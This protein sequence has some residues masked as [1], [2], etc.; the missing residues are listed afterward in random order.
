VKPGRPPG[1][2]M[3]CGWRCDARL[4]ARG[5]RAHFNNCTILLVAQ[6]CEARPDHGSAGRFV[7]RAPSLA[8]K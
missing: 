7:S 5:I 8:A 3:L 6:K 4:T 1:L 2:R